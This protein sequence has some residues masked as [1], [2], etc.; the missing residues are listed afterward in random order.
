MTIVITETEFIAVKGDIMFKGEEVLIRTPMDE[1][2]KKI[3]QITKALG[4]IVSEAEK[5]S[6]EPH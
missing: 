1:Q 5:P 4:E 6:N 3:L 2:T